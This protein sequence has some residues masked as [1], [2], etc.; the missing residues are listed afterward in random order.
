MRYY[1][2]TCIFL[3]P[4]ILFSQNNS[5]GLAIG[6][7]QSMNT[8]LRT[9][10]EEAKLDIGTVNEIVKNKKEFLFDEWASEAVVVVENKR[11]IFP[12][13][14]YNMNND[15]FIT[16]INKDSAF[17]L[18]SN[19]FDKVIINQKIFKSF[20]DSSKN[21]EGI[22]EVIFEKEK[23]SIVKKHYLSVM[24]KSK[25]IMLSQSEPDIRKKSK[26]LLYN[27]ENKVFSRFKLR[28]KEILGLIEKSNI[29]KIE[30]F[31]KSEK[32]S[33]K[34][35]EDVKKIFRYNSLR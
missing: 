6:N 16:R 22:Y 18:N 26:Y 10:L 3:L 7:F 11:Y 31:V 20:Y 9:L 2:F 29:S 12:N 14:N 28:K 23:I 15:S 32:L 8:K 21:S 35:E 24:E 1:F 4:F 33:Y 19:L 13:V 27:N 5:G 17:I 30:E 34:R 25:D